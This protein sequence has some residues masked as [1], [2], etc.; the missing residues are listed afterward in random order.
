MQKLI[1]HS[2]FRKIIF[3]VLLGLCCLP[4]QAQMDQPTKIKDAQIDSVRLYLSGAEVFRSEELVLRAG[5]NHYVFTGLSSK[6]YPKSIRVA[7]GDP[8]V[9]IRSV[10]SK[11]DFLTK[12]EQDQRIRQLQDSTKMVR[13]SIED[14][15]DELGAFK[16]ERKLLNANE[17]FKGEDKTLTAEELENLS[18]F[19][20][21]RHQAINKAMTKRN[22]EIAELNRRLFDLKLMLQELNADQIPLAEVHLVVDSDRATQTKIDFR[23]VVADAGWVAL[24][25]LEAGDLSE[26][27]TLRYRA[28]AYNNTGVDWKNINITLT[29]IDPLQS[30]TQPRL[31]V[32]DITNFSG[33]YVNQEQVTINNNGN[34][35]QNLNLNFKSVDNF[36]NQNK[37]SLY[38]LKQ[39]EQSR[40]QSILGKDF[41][42]GI[43]YETDLYRAIT[44]E[45]L[46]GG[47]ST[48]GLVNVTFPDFN[49][50]FPIVGTFSLP[51]DKKPYSLEIDDFELSVTYKYYAVPRVDKDAFLIA[52]IVGWEDLNLVSGPVNIYNGAEYIGQS[53]LDIR[54]ISD[55]LSVSLGRDRDVVVTRLKVKGKTRKQ[56]L[57]TTMRE[58]N[59]FNINIANHKSTAIDIQVLD[60]VPI[61]NNK[62]VVILVDELTEGK[63]VEATGMVSWDFRLEAGGT[64]TLDFG[65]TVK[66]PKGIKAT[67]QFAPARKM[68]SLDVQKS[69]Y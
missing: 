40:F 50:D 68:R 26:P 16:E 61:S 46:A 5:R 24:Y 66:Y 10:T 63:L 34:S 41:R 57:G 33:A 11:T 19:Y 59:A 25:D 8:S 55:T 7:A 3:T 9:K 13:E 27:I 30:A 22:R 23:Y 42:E 43:D 58:S 2:P 67:L 28:N 17:S 60:Q 21:K 20:R 32:W 37:R 31:E 56:L 62:E 45:E 39:R 53:S 49:T 12:R 18:G 36:Y 47:E 65:Y 35:I 6:L 38:D 29:T 4:V 69:M 14:L 52:Q 44:N 54:N 1:I 51:S 15:N 64:R 48:S